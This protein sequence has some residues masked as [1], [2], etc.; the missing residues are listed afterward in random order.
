MS[1]VSLPV[2]PARRGILSRT[3]IA[4]LVVGALD[5]A[6]AFAL[7]VGIYEVTTPT[8]VLQSIAA[9]LLGPDDAR[10]GGLPTAI[11]GFFL[12]FVIALGWALAYA[13]VYRHSERLR[14][15]V[16]TTGRALVAGFVAGM[17][18]WLLMN[19]VVVP[20]SATTTMPLTSKFWLM[21]LVGHGF[22][23]GLPLG[24]IVREP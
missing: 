24:L 7:Y 21:Q 12:H 10:A 3:L 5:L 23:G 20:L 18:V 4:G 17:I 11:L 13:L 15:F 19:R 9:G 6:F 8:R 2:A 22:F 16:E 14:R 1:T